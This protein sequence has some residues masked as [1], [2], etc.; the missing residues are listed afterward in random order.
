[1]TMACPKNWFGASVNNVRRHEKALSEFEPT[2]VRKIDKIF[3][4]S[5]LQR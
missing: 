4:A 3:E 2:H 5:K 1:M